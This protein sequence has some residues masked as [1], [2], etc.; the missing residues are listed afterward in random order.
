MKISLSWL[1]DYLRTDKPVAEIARILTDAGLEVGAIESTGVAI[2]KVVAAQ[3]LESIQHPN[4]DRLSV[5]KVDDG[6]GMPR[7]IV[8]GAK[9]YKVGDKVPLAQ[10]GAVMPGDFKN[11]VGKLRGVESEGMM[12]SSKELGLGEGADGLLILPSETSIGT[13]LSELFPA[14]EV[15]EI[16]ITPNRPDWLGHLG[17]AR[18][19]AAFGCGDLIAK[20]PD[21]PETKQDALVA[22]I[23]TP[24]AASFYSIRRIDGV[25]VGPSPEWLRKRLES[26]G[27]RSINNIVDITNFVMFETAQPLHAFDAGKI[28][29]ALIVRFANEGEGFTALDGKEHK[30]CPNDLV[31]ADA[32]GPQAIAG[33]TGGVAS[34]VSEATT[35]ILLESALFEATVI[36]R[37]GRALGISTDSSYRFERGVDAQS[38]LTASARAAALIVELAGGTPSAEVVATGSLP[39]MRVVA[40]RGDRVRSLL[41]VDLDD[42]AITLLLAKLGLKKI[43]SEATLGFEIPSWRNDL[44]REVDLI[45][46]V[47][48]LHGINSITAKCAGIPA[49]SSEADKAYDFARGLRRR[50]SGGGFHEAR[51]GTLTGS[52]DQ[53]AFATGTPGRSGAAVSVR[54][55]MGEEHSTLRASLIPGLLEAVSRNLRHGTDSIRLFEIGKVYQQEQPEESMHLGLVMTGRTAPEN[56]RGKVEGER[57]LDL[58]DLKGFIQLLGTRLEPITFRAATHAS[59]PLAL[60]L[61]IAGKS[62]GILGVLSPSATR[63]V[64]VGGHQGQ[65]VVAELDLNALQVANGIGFSKDPKKHGSLPKFPAIR[66]D[67]ALL[68]E[69]AIPYAAVEEAVL[70]AKEELF[71][72]VIPFDVFSDPEGVKV[73]LGKKSLAIALTFL[74]PE[75]T[76]T[77]EEV[78]AA[79]TRI[80]ARL[81]EAAG[82]E[83]RG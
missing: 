69:A 70:G 5:C 27:L 37:S 71:S 66:R 78:N 21:L 12:C 77:T 80:V 42:S 44:T 6:S 54:N 83:V 24:G 4:A 50:L 43:T 14:E 79:V 34:G 30:L 45:E 32:K 18:E 26:V 55:P 82:A 1:R 63:E 19:A 29:G 57:S 28:E 35:S 3:I 22:A 73:P 16:E 33:I 68:M 7:Q 10:P 61:L 64:M 53:A 15:F 65:I 67:L 59:L 60:E 76:L 36:R 75:R 9:N 56:W 25:K 74:H 52:R 23:A 58:Y 72:S 13:P 11:K 20:E 51:S 48:R 46:E 81:R 17:V 38:V 62:I 39:A 8:C 47:A 40:L 31:I 2:P 41:G 49:H